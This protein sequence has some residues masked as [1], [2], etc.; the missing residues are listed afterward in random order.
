MTKV[1]LLDFSIELRA[2]LFINEMRNL[3]VDCLLQLIVSLFFT[4][5]QTNKSG[6]KFVFRTVHSFYNNYLDN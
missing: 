4:K 5:K 1:N 3:F 2:D 6:N